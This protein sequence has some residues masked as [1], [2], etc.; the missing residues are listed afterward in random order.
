MRSARI[1]RCSS[2]STTRSNRKGAPNENFAREV[3]ELFT[4]GEGHY[5][6]ED[7]KE[8]ARAFTG[9]SLDR[10]TLA[11]IVSPRAHDGGTKTV[12]G[13]SGALRRRRSARPPARA[14]R[15]RAVRDG[16]ALARI[17][18]ARPG[19]GGSA[20]HRRALPRVAITTSRRRCASCCF[21]TRSTQRRTAACSSS[22]RPSS[23]SAR[24]ARWASGR[25]A[26]CRF[27][28]AA[29]GMG[30]NLLSPPNVKGWPGGESVDQHDHAACA[31]AI[32]RSRD[33]RRW[34]ADGADAMAG[35]QHGQ[36]R[37][38]RGGPRARR[39]SNSTARAFIAQFP[40][41]SP[42]ERARWAQ[43]LLLPVPPQQSERSRGRCA[44]RRARV[45]RSTPR[46]N[47]SDH[48]PPHL[49]A[50]VAFRGGAS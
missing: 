28:I 38:R 42:D 24:C 14:P 10:E 16:E 27:A 31:Q 47:S 18:F 29:A 8:A 44:D 35:M 3:M 32:R 37:D 23:S 20:A 15:D 39:A 34:I 40:G 41:A 5:T 12:L 50:V 26:S 49:P 45:R 30:Q 43:R 2:T 1:R 36:R 4:L 22:R 6:E 13:K 17:R 25:N 33:A 48:G 11:F 9:W 21:A 7:V 19:S 46:I